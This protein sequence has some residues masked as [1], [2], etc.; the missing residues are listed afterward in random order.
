MNR[1]AW[2]QAQPTEND[3]VIFREVSRGEVPLGVGGRVTIPHEIRNSM[4]LLG[5]EGNTNLCLRV[6]QTR[7]RRGV[8]YQLVVWEKPSEP[9]DEG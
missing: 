8:R 1:L 7:T 2:K 4:N 9:S 6:E 5:K 3:M